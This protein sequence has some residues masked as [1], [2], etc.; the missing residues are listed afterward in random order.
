MKYVKADNRVL[1]LVLVIG[2]IGGT[3]AIVQGLDLDYDSKP[4]TVA[5]AMLAGNVKITQIGPDG[6]VIA[7]RQT[8]NHIVLR[9]MELI[10]AQVFGGVNG[11]Y[12]DYSLGNP[13]P[14]RFM[15]IGTGG[16]APLLFNNTD[17]DTPV[18]G[19]CG[20]LRKLANIRNTTMPGGDGPAH[21]Y[22]AAV[23]SYPLCGGGGGEPDCFA[24]MNVTATA[25]FLGGGADQCASL[26]IDEAGIF[27][28]STATDGYMFARN[29]FG[30]V[31]LGNLDTLQLDWEFTFTDS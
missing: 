26:S 19:A 2:S 25:S 16:A 29:T 27:D 7:Y 22:N 15:Q 3:F 18:A 23:G 10:M 9:G 14:V 12:P 1:M 28:N 8:D 20:T 30:S 11:T 17:I 24:R 6:N 5:G 13:H 4:S 21:G 31:D